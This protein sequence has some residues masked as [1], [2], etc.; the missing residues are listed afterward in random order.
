MIDE[1]NGAEMVCQFC[2]KKY[3]FDADHLQR[4]LDAVKGKR[5][6]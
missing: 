6:L 1:D 5:E 3:Y 4:I 2:E